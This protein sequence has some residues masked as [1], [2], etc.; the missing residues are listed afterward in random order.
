MFLNL[1]KLILLSSLLVACI[2]SPFCIAEEAETLEDLVAQTATKTTPHTAKQIA[3]LLPLSGTLSGPGNAVKDGF[4]SAYNSQKVSQAM[5]VRMYDTAQTDAV[6][7]YHQAL[8][9]GADMIIGPLTKQGVA[10]VAAISHP[11]PTL[12]LNDVPT[13]LDSQNIYHIDLSPIHEAIEVARRARKDGVSR[14]LIIAPSGAWGEDIA[15]A[16]TLEWQAL[17]G[18]IVDKLFYTNT[19]DLNPLLH[20]FLQVTEIK[21]PSANPTLSTKPAIEV[22]HRE[23]FDMI[24]LQAFPS[25]ARQ[26]APLLRYYYVGHVPVYATSSVYSGS[27]NKMSDKDLDGIIFCDI[28][29]IFTHTIPHKNWP[30][31]FNSYSRLYAL[32]MDSFAFSAGIREESGVFY[33]STEKKM[34]REL[35]FKQFKRGVAGDVCRNRLV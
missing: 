24:F 22:K 15:R 28:S 34:C 3:L 30:E 14:S 27:I 29:W 9:D 5:H 19:D 21:K 10:S 7:L 13:P 11:V 31:N 2:F 18:E 4:M 1:K 35:V 32:G 12:L 23:D 6:T 33:A 25:K 26:I 16:F 20:D 8:S 17:G